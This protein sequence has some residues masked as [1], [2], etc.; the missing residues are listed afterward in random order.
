MERELF[1]HIFKRPATLKYPFEKTQPPK[2]L[3]GRPV[4]N[5]ELCTG[6]SLCY[7]DC[8]SGAI[9]MI[10]KG[11]EAEFKHYIDRCLFCGQC[12]EVCPVNA[13]DMTEEY[14]L[15]TSDRSGMI[16]EYKRKVK[17]R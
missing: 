3:R 9:D 17:S 15:A 8:P 16:I 12:K 7:R 4:W 1:Q 13:I 2:D 11:S 5:I 14:E 6:C 10:G